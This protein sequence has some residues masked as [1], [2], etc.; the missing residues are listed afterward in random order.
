M[1]VDWLG[2]LIEQECATPGFTKILH[3]CLIMEEKI[4]EQ[5]SRR[6]KATMPHLQGGGA[7]R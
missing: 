1:A 2:I 4:I 5:L 7:F 6:N 3:S